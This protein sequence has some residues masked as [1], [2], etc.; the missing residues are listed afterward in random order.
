MV[1]QIL[2]E[3]FS[4]SDMLVQALEDQSVYWNDDIEFVL[5]MIIKTLEKFSVKSA[6]KARLMPLFKNEEDQEYAKKLFRKTIINQN[7]YKEMIKWHTKN[8][9][10]DRIAFLDTLIMQMAICE[11]MEF[12]SIP[13]KVSL[14][15]YIE[16]AK[17]YSTRKSSTF[18]NGVLDQ[19]IK[20]LQKE[21]KIH[22]A[23]RGL[24]NG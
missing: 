17:F 14:N 21:G 1:T 6:N 8:W 10:L 9:E 2:Q 16:I 11:I 22:K 18:I 12:P 5:S 13:L 3:I 23:G 20:T 19:V 15:E 24:K 7:D 4:T